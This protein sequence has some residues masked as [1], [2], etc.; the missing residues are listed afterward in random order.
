MCPRILVYKFIMLLGE[1]CLDVCYY[2]ATILTQSS[3]LDKI[4]MKYKINMKY[5][6]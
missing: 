3:L 1:Q 5:M 6:I 4:D 2:L